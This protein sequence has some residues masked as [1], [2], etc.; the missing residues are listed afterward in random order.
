MTKSAILYVDDESANLI[1]FKAS[2]RRDFEIFT[3]LSANEAFEILKKETVKVIVSDQ[4]MPIMTGVEFLTISAH[5]YPLAKR[6]ILTGFAD[7][8][9]I[10]KAINEGSVYRYLT[11]PWSLDELRSAINNAIK[12]YDLESENKNLLLNLQSANDKLEL[13]AETLE[14]QVS[15][16]TKHL[17]QA[18]AERDKLFSIIAHDIRQPLGATLG[19]I[20]LVLMRYN[21][22]SDEKIISFVELSVKSAKSLVVLIEDLLNWSKNQQNGFMFS[23]TQFDVT[24][25]VSDTVS[26]LQAAADNKKI[27]L[28]SDI[29]IGTYI[30]ADKDMVRLIFRNLIAN[31]I[32]FCYRG[33]QVRISC[34]QEVDNI[35]FSINDNGTGMDE[36]SLQ[37]L[38]DVSK[39]QTSRGTNNEE[40]TGLGL[41]LVAEFVNQNGGDISVESKVGVGSTFTFSIPATL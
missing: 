11:K 22:L 29:P 35:F 1:A 5:E 18:L 26:L 32:K 15:D 25:I 23:P 17:L 19:F 6:I 9:V 20:E 21:N 31:S 4:R 10:I 37:T 3:A 12:L 28:H 33:G 30:M 16:R 41:V 38:F 24:E 8:E 14:T 40:G 2:F 36:V 34:K 7:I 13:Y 27:S 39:Y